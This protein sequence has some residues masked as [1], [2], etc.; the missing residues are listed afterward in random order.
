MINLVRVTNAENVLNMELRN[1]E[2][3]GFLVRD[4]QGLGSGTS[5][6]RNTDYAS[7]PGSIYDSSRKPVRNIVFQLRLLWHDTVEKARHE[8]E[9][10]FPLGKSIKMEFFGDDRE[11]WIEGY[12]ESNEPTIFS[13]TKMEGIDCQISVLCTD[14]AFKSPIANSVEQKKLEGGFYFEFPRP[15]DEFPEIPGDCFDDSYEDPYKYRLAMSDILSGGYS[16][17]FDYDG[18]AETGCKFHLY[19]NE[20][21]DR[22][23]IICNRTGQ[24]LIFKPDTENRFRA[25]DVMI[26]DT[27]AGNRSAYVVREGTYI[28]YLDHMLV[29]SSFSGIILQKGSNTFRLEIDKGTNNDAA[30]LRIEYRNAYWSV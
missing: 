21:A 28:N 18:T 19:F 16:V 7:L 30:E 17:S 11:T 25:G 13:T 20:S 4:I 8:S 14:P 29:T 1:P 6:I 24:S 12:V 10:Y 27:N 26:I 22:V 9:R 2:K 5:D 23:E 15:T 3:S